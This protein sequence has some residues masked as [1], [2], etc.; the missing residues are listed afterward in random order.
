MAVGWGDWACLLGC[1]GL[2]GGR[3]THMFLTGPADL[4]QK[5]GQ[6]YLPRGF[7]TSTFFISTGRVRDPQKRSTMRFADHSQ[8]GRGS[9]WEPHGDDFLSSSPACFRVTACLVCL[10]QYLTFWRVLSVAKLGNFTCGRDG[11]RGRRRP[12][13][14]ICSYYISIRNRD[15]RQ[16][17]MIS[18]SSPSGV[19]MGGRAW[20][21]A[22]QGQRVLSEMQAQAESRRSIRTIA[23]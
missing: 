20:D 23:L 21:L 10:A 17:M 4:S 7:E 14:R 1:S 5:C 15:G 2:E 18:V 19:S 13:F 9:A 3:G 8:A 6:S 16:D 22:P 12:I 11:N